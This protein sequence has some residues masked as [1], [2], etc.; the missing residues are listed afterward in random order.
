[1]ALVVQKFGGSSV[2]DAERVFN[3]AKIITDC[4]SLGNDVIVVLSA[5]GKTT[6]GLISK[7]HEINPNPSRREMDVLLSTGEQISVALMAMAIERLGF[8]VV[9][10]TGWQA[11]IRTDSHYSDA[12]IKKIGLERLRSELDRKN[13]VIV[14]GFQGVN[15][16]EDITTLGRGGS[17]TTAVAL[18]AA[19]VVM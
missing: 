18:A 2:A 7:A 11:D 9:S 19:I 1:M 3:V 12:R 16:Y 15:K 6:D 5:Q 10:L 13:I 4:Y 8:P 14:T 17:D